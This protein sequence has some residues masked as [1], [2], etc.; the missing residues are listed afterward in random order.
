VEDSRVRSDEALLCSGGT[1][2]LDGVGWS[3]RG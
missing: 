1:D 2:E 3:T